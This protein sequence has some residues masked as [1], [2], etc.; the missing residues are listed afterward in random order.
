MNGGSGTSETTL[1]RPFHVMTKP[2][3]AACNLECEY[4]YYLE[5]SELYPEASDTR[6]S[7]E[8]LE[9]YVEQYIEAQPGPEVTFAWQGGE[10]TLLGLDFFR[11][12][13]RLQE[14]HAPPDKRIV[15]TIQT[16]G[17][18]LNDE[19]C[20]FFAEHDFLVGISVDGPPDLHDEYRR[21]R[22][23]GPTF[24]QVADG[25]S[26][27]QDHGVEYNV[28][29]VVNDRNSRHP[30]RVYDF[31]KEQGV[32]WL[33]FIP[34]VEPVDGEAGA[35]AT[36]RDA[37]DGDE[38][39]AP[40]AGVQAA[41]VPMNDVPERDRDVLRAARA[42]PVTDRSV[43]PIQY[44]EFM[45][46][47]FDEWVRNDVGDVSVRLFDQ[48]LEVA[49]EGHA[50]L[51]LFRETCGD[52]VAMEHN[53]D[54]Y[55]CDHYVEPGF[56]LGNLHE[57]HLAELVDSE[58][59]R[60]FGEFKREGLPARCRKCAVREFCHGGCPKNRIIETP[61]GELGLNYLCAGYRRVFS[62][63]QP[64]L[65]IFKRVAERG[66]PLSAAMDVVAERDRRRRD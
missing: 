15:N 36:D 40:S 56:E 9:T 51:C 24:E 59:Q 57:T 21:S 32:R 61:A 66:H 10:P 4:C 38:E 11:E 12:V 65:E 17:T 19:W 53:G 33:Q 31:F 45:C 43:D 5:K 29:C 13:V 64:H 42:A 30:E 34:L 48:C 60:Q 54:V 27:L 2:T 8:T 46:T 55:A 28:L 50:S 3:G 41:G 7:A 18:R 52:Q 62:H 35:D 23:D 14:A 49:F 16:N 20:R 39:G 25:L 44:G 22:A 6:M 63:V 37:V 47:I 1:D 26:L 58:A